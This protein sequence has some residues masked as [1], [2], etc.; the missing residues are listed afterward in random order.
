[1][2]SSSAI[3]KRVCV[4]SFVSSKIC[5]QKL[6]SE[7]CLTLR[8]PRLQDQ[9]RLFFLG[10]AGQDLFQ[11]L[12]QSWNFWKTALRASTSCF[13][14][15]CCLQLPLSSLRWKSH[16]HF[17]FSRDFGARTLSGSPFPRRLST[18]WI[19]VVWTW[20]ARKT[21]SAGSNFE[22]IKAPRCKGSGSHVFKTFPISFY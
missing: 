10:W 8:S 17:L 14:P 11:S 3:K 15:N 20:E 12:Y 7:C 6:F 4:L 13:T 5:P 2:V 1:M 9:H 16:K 21:L 19:Y 18:S 22:M